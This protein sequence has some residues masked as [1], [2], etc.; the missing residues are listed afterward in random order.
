MSNNNTLTIGIIILAIVGVV[1][2]S[3]SKNGIN[4]NPSISPT[5]SASPTASPSPTFTPTSTPQ[6]SSTPTPSVDVSSWKTYRNDEYGF[7]IKYPNFFATATTKSYYGYERGFPEV[8]L[9]TLIEFHQARYLNVDFVI[10]ID[11]NEKNIEELEK[12]YD[13]NSSS[14]SYYLNSKKEISINKHKGIEY[15][16][17]MLEGGIDEITILLSYNSKALIISTPEISDSE[18]IFDQMLSTFKFIR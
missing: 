5:V 18:E 16:W 2:Y 12:I 15:R 4:P 8:K 9:D 7:E 1:A 10:D 6:P 11:A 14:P 17:G 3:L 13:H